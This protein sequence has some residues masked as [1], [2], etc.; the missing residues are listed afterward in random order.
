M[1]RGKHRPQRHSWSD[2]GV[3]GTV[4]IEPEGGPAPHSGRALG[5]TRGLTEGVLVGY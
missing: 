3:R 2:L 5:W 4:Q 1:Q